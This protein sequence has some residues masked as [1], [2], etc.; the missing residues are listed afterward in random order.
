MMADATGISGGG[1]AGRI[2]AQINSMTT[3]GY[4]QPGEEVSMQINSMTP[5]GRNQN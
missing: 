2:D 4:N 1:S 3:P 5:Q